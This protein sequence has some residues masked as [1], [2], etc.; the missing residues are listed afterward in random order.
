MGPDNGRARPRVLCTEKASDDGSLA[1]R[2]NADAKCPWLRLARE[3][4]RAINKQRAGIADQILGDAARQQRK[5]TE[6]RAEQKRR[7]E[8]RK[9]GA[10]INRR[11]ASPHNSS[12]RTFG[13]LPIKWPRSC[14]RRSGTGGGGGGGSG[15]HGGGHGDGDESIVDQSLFML[16]LNK[17]RVKFALAAAL[18]PVSCQ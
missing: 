10:Q 16:T 7:G 5:F 8:K 18:A 11:A 14:R 13:R 12:A 17:T 3:S 6:S 1:G 2:H 9:S 15:G 4:A